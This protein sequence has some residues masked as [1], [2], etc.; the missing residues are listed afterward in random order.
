LEEQNPSNYWESL[1]ALKQA[2][3]YPYNNPLSSRTA[4]IKQKPV[5]VGNGTTCRSLSPERMPLQNGIEEQS[6]L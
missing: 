1:T 2:R 3:G 5:M 6:H 4:K